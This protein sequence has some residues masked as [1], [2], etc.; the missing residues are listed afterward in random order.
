[1][2]I[3]TYA[4]LI[5]QTIL[6]PSADPN[7]IQVEKHFLI[8]CM[9]RVLQNIRVDESWYLRAYPDVHEAISK[10]IVPDP[11]SHYCSFGFYE[12]RMPYRIVID[13]PWYLA[14]YSDVRAAIARRHFASGQAHFDLDGFRE[15]R[16][17]Y[18]A[19]R[20][21]LADER[22][23]TGQTRSVGRG[24]TAKELRETSPMA[25]ERSDGR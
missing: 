15:G 22:S 8:N 21:E 17:P 7:Y 6:V 14:E 5:N 11:K 3:G 25:V 13:E 4:G 2:E 16:I 9:F 12:H 23:L 10:G 24:S 1:M 18:P 20:L 19:F